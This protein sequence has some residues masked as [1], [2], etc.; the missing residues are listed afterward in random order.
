MSLVRFEKI[1]KYLGGIPVLESVDLRIEEGEKVGLIGRNGTGKSTIFRLIMGELEPDGGL[2]ERMRRARIACLAQLSGFSEHDTIFD[3]VMASFQDLL[4]VEEELQ[5]LEHELASGD[6]ATLRRYGVVQEK[7]TAMGGYEFRTTARRVLH[8][9]GFRMEDFDLRVHALSGGQRTRL[10]LALVLL[11]DAD[12]LLLDEPEN[13]LDIEAR[14]WLEVFIKESPKAVVIIS[15]DRRMLNSVVDRVIEVEAGALVNYSGNYEYY[16]KQKTLLREQQLKAYEFQQQVIEKEQRFIDKFRYKNTKAKQ[17]QSRIKRLEKMEVVDAPPPESDTARFRF[18]EVVRT[19]QVVLDAHDLSMSYGDLTLYSRFSFQAT[20][21][22]RIGI[23]GPN[24]S[25]KTTLLRHLLGKLPGGRGE[26]A[27]GHKTKVGY[28]EQQHDAMRQNAGALDIMTEI[29]R[30]RPDMTSEQIRTFMGAFLFTGDDIFKPLSALSGG[31]LSR[32]ALARMILSEANV[33]ML[34]EPTNHLDIASREALEGALSK[35]PGS[36]ILV[37]HDRELIDKLAD[38]LVIVEQGKASV[39]LGNY[40]HYRWKRGE[41]EAARKAP[42]SDDTLKIRKR[43]GKKDNAAEREQRKL[44]KQVEDLERDIAA[45][46]Q[47]LEGFDARFLALDPT[48]Y[49]AARELQ[50]ERDGLENDLREL[51]AAWE[52]LAQEMSDAS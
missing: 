7:F 14:E 28:Y 26:V 12:L 4:Q 30:V 44:R 8:G 45:I 24:G 39:H 41:Q 23:I 34:D 32:V 25:G 42:P 46:E 27:L 49:G 20:R 19:G 48:D 2:I 18:G 29:Q 11:Q 31:E 37:S 38:K 52:D 5:R 6:E 21:G 51:Y 22:E 17:V 3:V 43:A 10:M 47:I 40:S 36:I 1:T 35:F 33:L 13:H 15:H 16:L 50:A 9:L